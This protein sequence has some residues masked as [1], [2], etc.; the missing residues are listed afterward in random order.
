MFLGMYTL[1]LNR[2][3]RYEGKEKWDVIKSGIANDGRLYDV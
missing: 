1:S 2:G 3:G